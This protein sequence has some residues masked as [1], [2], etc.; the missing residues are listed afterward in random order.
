M[1][2]QGSMAFKVQ[3]LKFNVRL[4]QCLNKV[5]RDLFFVVAGKNLDFVLE[6]L[7]EFRFNG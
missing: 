5:D 4:C 3:R 2:V 6:P 7:G 1:K